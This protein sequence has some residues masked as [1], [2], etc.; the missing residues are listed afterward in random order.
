VV[1]RGINFI[2]VSGF[3]FS[4][5]LFFRIFLQPFLFSGFYFSRFCFQAF[6]SAIFVFQAFSQPFLFSGFFFRHFCFSGFFILRETF[7]ASS[8]MPHFEVITTGRW[9][10][11]GSTSVRG[12]GPLSSSS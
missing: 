9:C 12:S 10:I 6:S 2:F 8:L 5:F 1:H 11:V 7:L 3:I 4:H